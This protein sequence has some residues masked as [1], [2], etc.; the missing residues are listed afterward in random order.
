ML[1]PPMLRPVL[2]SIMLCISALAAQA[3]TATEL[4]EA[5][6]PSIVVVR[7]MD[8]AGK[9]NS[10]GSGVVIAN[11]VVVTNCH[12]V[13][14]SSRLAVSYRGG[15]YAA[16]LRHSDHNRDVCSLNVTGMVAPVATLGSTQPLKVGQ[17][18]Y[19]IGA[20]KGLDLTLSEGIIS[21]LREVEAGRYLQIS[22][23][24]SPG[25]SG[26][27]LFDEEGRLIGLPTFYLAE[28][29]QLNFAVPV[30]WVKALPQRHA[31]ANL[32]PNVQPSLAWFNKGIELENKED[33]PGLLKHMQTWI[34]VYPQDA[35][36]WYGL[37][38]AYHQSG[39]SVKAIEAFQQA[40]RTNPEDTK[41]WTNL[42]VAYNQLGQ[43]AK[44][45][46]AF[47][48]V[49]RINPEDAHAWN[50]I[51]VAY[52][53]SGQTAKVI[54]AYQQALRI[55][56]EYASA[57]YNLGG[58][59]AQSGQ[60][61]KAIE[62]FQQALRIKPEDADAWHNLAVTYRQS[63]QT[64]KA[65]EAFQQALRINPG[66]AKVW[67]NLGSA[68]GRSG[69]TAKAI[70][71]LQQAL[72]INPEHTNAWVFLGITYKMSGQTHKVMEVHRQLKRLDP[73]EAD[74]FFNKYVLP[75]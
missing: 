47:Q 35:A 18:V 1:A 74:K 15:L 2:S 34:Q 75:Q 54:E 9:P 67:Y 57:W 7:G 23:P 59:Y 31:K 29:Q 20:P 36:A 22:A 53:E 38:V 62:A 16:T 45:I 32:K 4:F 58:A 50:N 5:V 30:E 8:A 37:G 48:Q 56:P 25:S 43:T 60:S 28:G 19:A 27:G 55:N 68:Y 49:L 14:K 66:D 63:N 44:A 64:A 10:L 11:D 33:W 70:E 12:V 46:E 21:S 41:A 69:Q 65:I 71:A 17:K 40:L 3:K 72:R 6:S 26:G 42:G 51:G 61:T 24:I 13:N 39:Q 52:R 73:A